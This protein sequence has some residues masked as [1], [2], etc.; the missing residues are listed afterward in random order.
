MEYVAT[1]A[2]EGRYT[3]IEFPDCEGCQTFSDPEEGE[4]AASVA[5]DALEGWLVAHLVDGEAPPPPTK[6]ASAGRGE[7]AVRVSPSL[8]IALQVRWRRQALGLSQAQLGKRLGV[9]RQQAAALEDPAG[10]LRVSTLERI[11]DALA[12]ELEVDLHPA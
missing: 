10:N 4:D 8:A 9:T 12:L 6:R 2:R 3:L 11:A 5:R 1:L 7:L